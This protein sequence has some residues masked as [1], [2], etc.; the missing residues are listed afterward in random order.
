MPSLNSIVDLAVES[1]TMIDAIGT[2]T[3]G[4]WRNT[5]KSNQLIRIIRTT[6]PITEKSVR[7]L[8]EAMRE[9][10]ATRGIL[11]S[12]AD[13]SPGAVDFAQSRPIDLVEKAQVVQMLQSVQRQMA[14][15][16]HFLKKIVHEFRYYIIKC[17]PIQPKPKWVLIF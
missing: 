5:K 11:I 9:K 16:G 14:W 10:N 4:K 6:D 8:H 3:H 1:D 12:T 13:F 7:E 15:S 17:P 2:I